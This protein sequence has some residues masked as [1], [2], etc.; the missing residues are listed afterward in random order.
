MGEMPDLT[1]TNV[2]RR[3]GVRPSTLR[4]YERIGLLP[5]PRRVA[6]RRRYDSSALKRLGLIVFAKQAGF[7]LKEI[8]TIQQSRKS[9]IQL[10]RDLA[11]TKATELD[12]VILRAEE[13]KR[14]LAVLSRCRCQD[15]FECSD[16]V[17]REI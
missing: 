16:R 13:A 8:Q 10:W 4:Y 7:S 12:R 5:P 6:G 9:P 1:I 14:R 3:A 11:A 17:A 15:F 2:A